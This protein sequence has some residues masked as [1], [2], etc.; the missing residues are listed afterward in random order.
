[1]KSLKY[2]Y[3]HF[4]NGMRFYRWRSFFSFFYSF[5]IFMTKT[6]R[7][8]KTPN[9]GHKRTCTTRTRIVYIF[10]TNGVIPIEM[11]HVATRA[12]MR[13]LITLLWFLFLLTHISIRLHSPQ[14]AMSRWTSFVQ[15]V[16]VG[17]RQCFLSAFLFRFC[18]FHSFYSVFNRFNGTQWP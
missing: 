18:H 10:I 15:C 8:N 3:K 12:R 5:H 4:A 17:M 11:H 6:N 16:C 9:D 1:M 13:C 14:H 2:A 7:K